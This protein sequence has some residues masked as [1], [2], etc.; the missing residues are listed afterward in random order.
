MAQITTST[1]FKQWI[2]TELGS[3]V[4][5]IE[6]ADAHLQQAIDEAVYDFTRYNYGEGSYRD[7]LQMEL[8]AGVSE[9]SLSGQDVNSVVD[10]ILSVGGSGNIN[11]L[12]TPVNMI[13]S[14]M[15]FVRLGNFQILDYHVAMM[16]LAEIQEYFT[17]QFVGKYNAGSQTL[18]VVP[19]PTESSSVMLEIYKKTS[20]INLYN[21]QLVKQ[22]ALARAMMIWGRILRKYTITLPGG[23]T[24]SG[25]EIL[26]DAKELMETVMGNLKGEG[27]PPGFFMA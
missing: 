17:V 22:L 25:P 27:E 8:S 26:A 14:P 23:G 15:D 24:L 10:M 19:T 4:I 6:L 20:A 7:F 11:M 1:E 5:T 16:K 12:F 3:P 21:N 18:N 9:Y 13:L 2:L